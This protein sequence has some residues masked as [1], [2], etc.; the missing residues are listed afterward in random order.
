[1]ADISHNDHDYDEL[2]QCLTSGFESLLEEVQ[3]LAS[4]N[5]SLE[6]RLADA[7][8]QVCVTSPCKGSTSCM[9]KQH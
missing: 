9:K 4:R 7:Q 1:M 2:V 6:Q 8:E 3:L 5:A